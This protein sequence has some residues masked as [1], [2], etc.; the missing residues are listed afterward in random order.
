[1]PTPLHHP[2]LPPFPDSGRTAPGMRT[3]PAEH[4]PVHGTARL[5]IEYAHRDGRSLVLHLL[6]PAGERTG[7]PLLVHVQGSAWFEQELG[8]NLPALAA[9]A[10][11]G[12]AVATVAYRPSTVAPFP[13]QVLDLRAA[14]RFLHRHAGEFGLDPRRTALWGD[15]SGGHTV[16]LA[17]LTD[18]DPAFAHPEEDGHGPLGVRAVVDYYGPTDIAAMSAEPSAIDHDGPD[19]PEGRLIGGHRVGERPDLVAPTLAATHVRPGAV[20]P[21]FLLVHGSRDRLVPFGQSVLLTEALQRAGH[22]VDLVRLEGA[23]HGGPPFWSGTVLDLV[24]GFL[25]THLAQ[26]GD[27]PP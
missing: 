27:G 17:A 13:A 2:P 10:A 25:R 26:D 15:S 5:G 6:V 9:F 4:D 22:R 11:R 24:D 16:V 1:M 3:L 18:G 21:P 19:S 20:L 8:L 12:Y 14:V 23:D 7:L